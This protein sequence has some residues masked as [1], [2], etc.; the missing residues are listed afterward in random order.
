MQKIDPKVIENLQRMLVQRETISTPQI[1]EPEIQEV[2]IEELPE[3]ESA[4]EAIVPSQQMIV[5]SQKDITKALQKTLRD[6]NSWTP[7]LKPL[8]NTRQVV[9]AG[10]TKNHGHGRPK[11]A[12][13]LASRMRR[14]SR[15]RS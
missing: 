10:Y 12:R 2:V 13:K 1:V 15:E 4:S 3:S 6:L 7:T 11:Q 14:L 5:P 9:R 8:S